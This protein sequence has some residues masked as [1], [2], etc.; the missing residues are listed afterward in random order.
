MSMVTEGDGGS[1]AYSY[2]MELRV[3]SGAETV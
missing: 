2:A 3:G 1:A